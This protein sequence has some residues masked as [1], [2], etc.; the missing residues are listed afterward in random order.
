MTSMNNEWEK[1]EKSEKKIEEK[2][3]E[4]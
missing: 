1:L 4:I 2:K 3:N